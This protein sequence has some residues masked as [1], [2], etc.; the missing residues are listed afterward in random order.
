[1][2]TEQAKNIASTVDKIITNILVSPKIEV[3]RSDFL[4]DRN[5][6]QLTKWNSQP[7]NPV[8]KTIHETIYESVQ[9]SPDAEA[10]CSWDGILTYE[11]LD[12]QACRL[13]AHLVTKLGVGPET[14]VLLC[15]DKSKWNIVAMLAVLMAGGACKPYLLIL[16]YI[17]ICMSAC[18]LGLRSFRAYRGASALSKIA[19]DDSSILCSS[20]IAHTD[21]V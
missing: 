10:V 8:E 1:V 4:S 5:K 9:R 17:R 19:Q 7:L 21:R 20:E 6:A 18:R 11:Q 13:A 3:S 14:I 2:P 15:F 16:F 12:N